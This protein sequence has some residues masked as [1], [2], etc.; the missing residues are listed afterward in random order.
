M[1]QVI[2]G[3]TRQAVHHPT[4][5][6]NAFDAMVYGVITDLRMRALFGQKLSRAK[7]AKGMGLHRNSLSRGGW[8]QVLM[9]TYKLCRVWMRQSENHLADKLRDEGWLE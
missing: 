2:A 4:K 5:N 6:Q 8:P 9:T 1:A 7:I 3:E